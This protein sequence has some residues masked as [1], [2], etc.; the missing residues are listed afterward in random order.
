LHKQPALLRTTTLT[1]F[2]TLLDSTAKESKRVTMASSLKCFALAA[3]ALALLL[4]CAS[5]AEAKKNAKDCE[6][7]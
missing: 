6:G 3:V 7:V 5:P 2:P 4:A 1:N